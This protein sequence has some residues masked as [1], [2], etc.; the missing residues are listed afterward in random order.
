VSKFQVV[1]LA[2]P[3][4]VAA[5]G[6]DTVWGAI[7]RKL[8]AFDRNGHQRLEANL[9]GSARALAVGERSVI[10]AMDSGALVWVD[11]KAGEV[12]ASKSVGRIDLVGQ[13]AVAWAID[14]EA[15][16]ARRVAES[17]ELDPP[18]RLH[19]PD[20]VATDG[21]RLW[22]TTR[23]GS[24]L[25]ESDRL[26]QLG[27]ECARAHALAICAGSAWISTDAGLCRVGTWAA[28]LGRTLEVARGPLMFL[29]CAD[30][31]LVGAAEKNQLFVLDPSADSDGRYFEL[32]GAGAIGALVALGETAWVFSAKTPEV[33]M[34]PIRGGGE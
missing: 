22:W 33:R 19:N 24:E 11:P 9:P 5:A 7:A 20:L 2:A 29:T 26:V 25:R 12:T 32:N 15:G 16:T 18:R 3:C 6:R 31:A 34:V 8:Y 23:D 13:G 21:E 28:E 27:P 4:P 1:E 30:G 10:V 14:R 17:G